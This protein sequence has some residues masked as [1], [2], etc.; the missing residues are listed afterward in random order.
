MT[1]LKTRTHPYRGRTVRYEGRT[2][3][4]GFSSSINGLVQDGERVLVR[5]SPV[6]LLEYE[7]HGPAGSYQMPSAMS[8]LGLIGDFVV[9]VSHR[10][11]DGERT[12]EYMGDEVTKAQHAQ[13]RLPELWLV[14]LSSGEVDLGEALQRRNSLLDPAPGLHRLHKGDFVPPC[15]EFSGYQLLYALSQLDRGDPPEVILE[16]L[17]VIVDGV[18]EALPAPEVSACGGAARVYLDGYGW[19]WLFPT[20]DGTYSWQA[21]RAVLDSTGAREDWEQL[22]TRFLPGATAAERA[23]VRGHFAGLGDASLQTEVA[24]FFASL[25]PV[26]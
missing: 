25:A 17:A 2:P 5:A 15:V 1:K 26:G 9:Y 23:L 18:I 22:R 11:F 6:T 16:G 21:L 13:D 7:M 3:V 20:A 24:D 19:R 8:G 14:D 10:G 12:E 4:G